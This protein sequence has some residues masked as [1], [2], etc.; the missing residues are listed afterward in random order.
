MNLVGRDKE[1]FAVREHLRT[2]KNLVVFGAEG[3]GKTAL[4][5]EAVRDTPDALQCAD[6]GT[7]KSAC[8]S[9]LA[10]LNLTV[11]EAD[12][13]VRKRAILK[14]TAGKNCCFVFDHVGWV[15]PKLLSFLENVRESHSMIVVTRSI[16]WSE[17]GHLRMLLWDFDQLELEPLSREA[18]REV[19]RVQMKQLQLRV[20]DRN[21]FEADV[22]RIADH[23]LHVLTGLCQQAASGKYVFGKHLS[24][25]LLDLD[26][27]IKELGLP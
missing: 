18:M 20:P 16:A 11:P 5:T 21:H 6:S 9:L 14:A 4:I 25:Q 15:S 17:M 7:L 2:G 3:I 10:Q 8:E 22:L 1:L 19:L 23:N 12:N 13:I 24:T 27:R 26:R